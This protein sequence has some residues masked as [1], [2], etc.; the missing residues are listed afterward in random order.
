MAKSQTKRTEKDLLGPKEVPQDAYWGVHTQRA[1]ENFQIS[2]V[3]VDYYLINAL[4]MVKKAAALTNVELGYMDYDKG[5]AIIQAADE[6]INGRFREEFPLD[7]LQGGAGT[8]TNM[9]LNE[10]IANRANEI[11]G[12]GKGIYD[13]VHPLDDVNQHQSTNDVY[14]TAVKI[15]AVFYLRELS[16]QIA[17][18]QGVFQ[19]KEKELASIIKMGRTELQDAV[20]ISLGAEFSAFAEAFAR[21]R[22]RTFKCEERLRTVNIG[23]TI[24]GTG[25]GAPRRYIFVM[26]ERLRDVTRLG[27][28]RAENLLGETAH[29]DVFIEV[30]GILKAHASSLIKVANDLR[31]LNSWKEIQLPKMQAGS[32]IMP[33]KVNP[34][35]LEATIQSGIKVMANDGIVSQ[36]TSRATLQI[37]EFLPLLSSALLESLRILCHMNTILADFVGKITANEDQCR[38]YVESCETLI[39]AL[40]PFIGYERCQELI[41]AFKA[42][43]QEELREFL[44]GKLDPALIDKIFTLEK[45][46]ALGFNE[47]ERDH[48]G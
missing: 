48:N 43:Q 5:Q 21:D 16:D 27:L 1:L 45:F 4:A 22:W 31:L 28:N 24:L 18:L 34:V 35:I 8:S 44:K 36:S 7:I 10:V 40:V 26:I 19:S 38:A 14:P 11:L 6:I 41:T 30:S 29:T 46:M 47:E 15:A 33:G 9:N 3:K 25:L 39:T 12:S 17:R 37:N 23:G 2:H 32:S 13:K 42:S 20:P